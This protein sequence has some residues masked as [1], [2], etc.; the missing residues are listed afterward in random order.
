MANHTKLQKRNHSLQSIRHVEKKHKSY[1][2]VENE[3]VDADE[4]KK[5]HAQV[6]KKHVGNSVLHSAKK[7]RK[8]K[9]IRRPK[10]PQQKNTLH[11][12]T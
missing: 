1:A 8:T 5:S 12:Q 6:E 9:T 7:L 2:Q 3:R 11:Q 10:R 4:K